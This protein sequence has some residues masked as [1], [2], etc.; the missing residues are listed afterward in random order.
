MIYIYTLIIDQGLNFP[1]YQARWTPKQDMVDIFKVYEIFKSASFFYRIVNADYQR[2][3]SFLGLSR[4]QNV[5]IV[6]FNILLGRTESIKYQGT[7]VIFGYRQVRHSCYI[8]YSLF[9][10]IL[11]NKESNQVEI[12]QAKSEFIR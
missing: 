12:I 9:F 5:I 6:C 8:S 1:L 2:S 7:G 11:L 3:L 10:I 4:S